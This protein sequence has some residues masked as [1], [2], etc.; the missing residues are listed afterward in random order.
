MLVPV[1]RLL[2][3]LRQ[4]RSRADEVRALRRRLRVERARTVDDDER[5]LAAALAAGKRDLS[6]AVGAVDACGRCATGRPWPLGAHDGG[7][8][9]AGT[10]AEL[11]DDAELAALAHAGTRPGDLTPPAGAEPHAGCA[12]RGAHSCSL[13]LAHRPARCVRYLCDTIRAELHR[14]GR[15][16]TIEL[17]LAT[18]DDLARRF[19]AAHRQRLDREVLAPI[20]A[21]LEA[22]VRR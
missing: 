6:Q 9:C 4:P 17:H 11:F 19:A 8:C 21:A 5:Q 2:R 20:I 7:A 16:D 12:F 1:G 14:R 13:D 15:L 3:R 10:T 22:A 18:V